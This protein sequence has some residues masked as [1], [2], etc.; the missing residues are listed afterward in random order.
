[1]SCDSIGRRPIG[2]SGLSRVW[3]SNNSLLN[4]QTGDHSPGYL[5]CAPLK[6]GREE[7]FLQRVLHRME[8]RYYV[9][10]YAMH[11]IP[12]VL[13]RILQSCIGGLQVLAGHAGH[14]VY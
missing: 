2:S 4:W 13:K 11:K 5:G 8:R 1:M 14:D 3:E 9:Q 7:C 12:T 10:V 6:E